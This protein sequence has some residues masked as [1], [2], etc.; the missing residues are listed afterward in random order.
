[1]DIREKIA[2]VVDSCADIPKQ[3]VEQY[4]IFVMPMVIMTSEGEFFDG[5]NITAQDVYELQKREMPKTGCPT[6]ATIIDTFAAVKNEGYT[7]AVVIALSGGL[8][9]TVNNIRMLAEDVE[10]LDIAVFDS[11]SASIGIGV[12]GIQAAAY[13]AEGMDFEQLKEK[14][15][16]LIR[17]TRVFFSIDTLEYLQKGG[18]IGK[19]T[20]MA[21]TLLKIKPVLSFDEKDGEIYTAAKVRGKNQVPGKLQ[22]LVQECQR[23][24]RRYNIVVADGGAP[25]EGDALE[26]RIKESFPDYEKLY[27]A[28]I[29]AALSVYL[30]DGLLGAGI[31]FLE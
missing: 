31:Q 23:D 12:I 20:A 18:R 1:M 22:E 17:N 8:S 13:V 29:G 2:V 30:G 6:G 5:V 27:R 26:E 3:L 24:G 10:G 7:K 16:A 21:G 28:K 14:I 15:Q 11:K 25:K 9:G 4:H 19:V